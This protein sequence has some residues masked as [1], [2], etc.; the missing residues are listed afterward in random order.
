PTATQFD[1]PVQETDDKK[2]YTA[3]TG[4]GLLTMS[5]SDPF[6]R[7]VSALTCEKAEFP[8]AP[9]ATQPQVPP[10]ATPA[11]SLSG[12]G[13]F[14]LLTMDQAEPFQCSAKILVRL[15]VPDGWRE[16]RAWV[17][18]ARQSDAPAHETPFRSPRT[19]AGRAG[20]CTIDHR[21]PSQPSTSA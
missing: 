12:P 13:R 2:L 20:P 6:Q 21:D 4:S 8:L 15:G 1:A 3:P 18:T 5:H 11:R 7:S 14:G 19:G 9:T 16:L 10:H 17:P